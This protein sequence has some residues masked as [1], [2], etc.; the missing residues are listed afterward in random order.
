MSYQ[1]DKWFSMRTD[2]FGAD[3][4]IL[5]LLHLSPQAMALYVG[6]IAYACRQGIDYT[7]KTHAS[8]VGIKRAAPVI[9][10][11]VDGGFFV[12]LPDDTYGVAHE[13]TLWR[14]GKPMQRR[15]IPVAIRA[16][17]MERDG[18]ACVECGSDQR[19]SLDHIWPYSKGGRD[20]LENLRV[21]C[22]SCNSSKGD[23]TDAP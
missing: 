3:S 23:R 1:P 9:R 7:F 5:G 13:G 22:Q 17:V 16:S 21:L 15:P 10:E 20:T 14:R 8:W 6:S 19:L 18:F 11:L 12:P 4:Y 2:Y